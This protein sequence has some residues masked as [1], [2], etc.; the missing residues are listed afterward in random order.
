MGDLTREHWPLGWIPSHDRTHGDRRGLLRMDNLHMDEDNVLSLVRGINKIN[1]TEF[2]GFVHSIYSR[3]IRNVKYRYVGLSTGEVWRDDTDFEN[4]TQVLSGGSTSETAFGAMLGSVFILSDAQRKR[5]YIDPI[6]ATIIT[7][8]ITPE[9][10]SEAPVAVGADPI[11]LYWL[12]FDGDDWTAIEGAVSEQSDHVLIDTDAS[13]FR[14]VS[15]F[16]P[17]A[18]NL[19]DTTLP[20]SEG[21]NNHDLFAFEVRIKDT[22]NLVKVRVEFVT[23]AAT[24][25]K[26]GS[27]GGDYYW[28]EW[29]NYENTPFNQGVDAWTT[30]SA[31]RW[32]FQR[33]GDAPFRTSPWKQIEKIRF[34]IEYRLA[35][36]TDNVISYIRWTGGDPGP[37]TGKYDYMQVNVSDNGS[38]QA[39]SVRSPI[40]KYVEV[41]NSYV[42]LNPQEPTDSSVNKIWIYR[43]SADYETA[44]LIPLGQEPQLDKWYRVAEITNSGGGWVLHVED[45]MSDRDAL[46]A[47]ISY[48]DTLASVKDHPDSILG[49]VGD[50]FGRAIYIT[51]K[52]ILV[53]DHLDPGLYQPLY[54]VRLGSADMGKLLWIK[55][56]REGLIYVGATNDIYAI[57]GTFSVSSANTID[58]VVTPIGTEQVPLASEVSEETGILYYMAS[59]G[60]RAVSGDATQSISEPL[61]LLY[62]GQTRYGVSGVLIAGDNAS[63][64]PVAIAKGKLWTAVPL[65]AN[66]ERRLFVYDIAKKYWYPYFTNPAQLFAEQDGKLLAGYGEGS[67]KFLREIDVGT[68]LD[69]TTGQSIVFETVADDND[70]P[71]NRKDLFTFKITADSGNV[72]VTILIA[73]NGSEQYYNI[74]SVAFD[75]KSEKLITV[76][77]TIGLAKSVAVRLQADNL[78]TF[79]LYRFTFE[80]DPRPEQLTYIRI[81]NVNLG[82]TSRK[83]FINYSF[84]IDTLGNTCEFIPLIDGVVAGPSS[85]FS[86][87]QKLTYIHYFVPQSSDPSREDEYVGTDIGGIIC[88]F[89]EFYHPNID[90]IVSEKLPV[91]TKFLFIPANNYGTPN[92]KRHSSYKFQLHSRGANV[93]FTPIV[94]GT[95]ETPAVFNTTRKEVVEYFFT[96]DVRGIDVHGILESTED[97]PFEFYGDITPQNVEVLPPRLKEFRL[98]ENNFGHAAKKRIR[99]IPMVINTNGEDVTFTP[100]VDHASLTASTF[101]TPDKQTVHHYFTTD[102]FG[103]D[104]SGE[105]L[106]SNGVPFEFYGWGKL[107][108]VEVLPVP[109]KFDQIGPLQF[110]RLAKIIRLRLRCIL[111]GGSTIP[112]KILS[113]TEVTLPNMSALTGVYDGNF[114]VTANVDD[115]WEVIIPE[116][117]SGTVFRI[118]LGPTSSPFHRYT[119]QAQ[120][121]ISGMQTDARWITYPQP[122]YGR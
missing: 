99:T 96:K 31:R 86:N 71:R 106:S 81:P 11:E 89:F 55:K 73:K 15:S 20:G 36:T 21:P 94:D 4:K 84:T 22:S 53:S 47:N 60:W 43:R 29:L 85:Q 74:G 18:A 116:T 91:P 108:E 77:E 14:S 63:T 64:Y 82:T 61:D 52:E 6:T 51:Y 7:H 118:E 40:Q 95:Y 12:N 72:P 62:Q 30:L 34:I 67:G 54:G 9:S 83:R 68:G 101:N 112:F 113:E 39:K 13:S 42:I 75:G 110:D 49:M 92:R 79:K 45:H 10:P 102:V 70:Q 19:R 8:D 1:T 26:G 117:V 120:V 100:I 119:L 121:K 50:Y 3:I 88:G 32:E 56:A 109:K 58:A 37:L 17:G 78:F 111:T 98:P 23:A 25:Y 80:Y 65:L 105:L 69:V 24:G 38:Y 33:E 76:A 27:T 104:F 46:I 48:D 122:Q 87:N 5:E 28:K 107:E 41:R 97:T 103:T 44:N 2:E 59:D 114:A 115:V 66:N 93:Q 57:S 90:E 16:D 35:A